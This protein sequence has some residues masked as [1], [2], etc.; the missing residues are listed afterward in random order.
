MKA[1]SVIICAYNS[2]KYIEECLAS[3]S[4]YDDVLDVI[5]VSD[6]STDN[7]ANIAR[8]FGCNVIENSRNIGLGMSRNIGM[9][10]VKTP[11]IMFLDSDDY[12]SKDTPIKMLNAIQ[13]YEIAVCNTRTFGDFERDYGKL[14]LFGPKELDFE[15]SLKTPCVCWNK[16][17][18]TKTLFDNGL[19]FSKKI[20]DDNPF[21][22][23]FSCVKHNCCVNYIDDVLCNYRQVVGSSFDAQKKSVNPHYDTIYGMFFMY[24]YLYNHR[25]TEYVDWFF[26]CY[27]FNFMI[28]YKNTTGSTNTEVLELVNSY[29][30]ARPHLILGAEQMLSKENR[31]KLKEV[32]MY[33]YDIGTEK[34]QK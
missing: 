9:M 8:K 11:Y 18:K 10:A 6:G 7:S 15:T 25:L 1:L 29:L 27:F 12:W 34:W 2:E 30:F 13:G 14:E 17:Y 16:I 3:T 19:F 32:L 4:G 22:F 5:V 20:P 28:H 24:D 33:K 26:D 23:L 21:W 31:E